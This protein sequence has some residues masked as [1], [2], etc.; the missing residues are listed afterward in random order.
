MNI[1][2]LGKGRFIRLLE[3]ELN[4]AG[5]PYTLIED[6]GDIKSVSGQKGSF[7][8]RN[9]SGVLTASYIVVA[10]EPAFGSENAAGKPSLDNTGGKPAPANAAGEPLSSADAFGRGIRLG[11]AAALE[12]APYGDQPVAFILDY[13]ED[14]PAHV[15]REALLWAVRLARKRYKV[16]FLARFLR[17]AGD[18][19]ESLYREARELGVLFFKY[20]N[21]KIENSDGIFHITAG[22]GADDLEIETQAPVFAEAGTR[23]ENLSGLIRLLRIKPAELYDTSGDR[24]FFHSV[25]TGRKGIYFINRGVNSGSDGELL[26]QALFI[27]SDIR[28]DMALREIALFDVSDASAAFAPSAEPPEN[29]DRGSV[30]G[31]CAEVNAEKCAFCYTCYRACPHFAM[32]PDHERSAMRNVPE[33]CYGCGI[34]VSVCPAN[35]IELKGKP[36]SAVQNEPGLIKVFCCENSG[37]IAYG[38]ILRNLNEKGIRAAAA[39]FA[40]GGEISAENVLEALKEYQYVLVAVCEDDACRHFEGN[41][42]ARLAVEHAKEMLKASGRDENRVIYTRLS[43]ASPY[44]LSYKIL[45]LV[46]EGKSL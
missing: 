12:D 39:P 20:I 1:A 16:V 38:R 24:F 28:R 3:T 15:T 35:A 7:A 2:L 25:L 18:G 32:E 11:D 21:I 22:D 34:C 31:A 27:I 36:E 14:S 42:R 6:A 45:E 43:P 46:G 8:I 44:E 40:C 33:S 17:T 19:L 41:K 13:P 9:S 4:K 29:R 30:S 5:L 26:A 37:L 23:D 10:G